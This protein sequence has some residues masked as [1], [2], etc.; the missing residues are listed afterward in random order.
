MEK[1]FQ[2]GGIRVNIVVFYIIFDFNR[3]LFTA[4]ESSSLR[5]QCHAQV[6]VPPKC[7]DSNRSPKPC[8]SLNEGTTKNISYIHA[9]CKQS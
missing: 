9:E 7:R 8:V 6:H 5:L 1:L 3:I 2:Q 4:L